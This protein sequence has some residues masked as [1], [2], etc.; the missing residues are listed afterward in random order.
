M[1][2]FI[3]GA[4]FAAVLCAAHAETAPDTS[5]AAGFGIQYLPSKIL[6]PG[7]DSTS[8]EAL[9]ALR[10]KTKFGGLQK[11][12][13]ERKTYDLASHSS[14]IQI[15]D[16]YTL[17]PKGAVLFV[18]PKMATVIVTEP[19]GTFV[20]WTE[21]QAL[22][23]GSLANFEVTLDQASGKTPID[24]AKLEFAKRAGNL[25]VAVILGGAVSVAPVP[26][27]PSVAP[28]ASPR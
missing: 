16:S 11:V 26:S 28:T 20:P 5:P 27:P 8:D 15:D 1:N 9:K 12:G 21:M 25:L 10:Q 23:R 17:V 2:Q 19:H 4:A 22:N 18:P 24:P 13:D 14:F 6:A 7:T 3:S